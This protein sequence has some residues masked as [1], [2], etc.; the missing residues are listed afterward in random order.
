MRQV[1]QVVMALSLVCVCALQN[2]LAGVSAH[3]FD[4]SGN[5]RVGAG[6]ILDVREQT[7]SPAF[8]ILTDGQT[9]NDAVGV[10][11]ARLAC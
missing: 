10:A 4:A 1:S 7:G 8:V 5:E 2:S 9:T 6:D 11:A 3:S